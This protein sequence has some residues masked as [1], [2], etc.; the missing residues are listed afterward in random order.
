MADMSS[1]GL[2]CERE[3]WDETGLDAVHTVLVHLVHLPSAQLLA[4]HGAHH[5]AVLYMLR[6]NVNGHVLPLFV[7]V[8]TSTALKSSLDLVVERS[9]RV[10]Q[11]TELTDFTLLETRQFIG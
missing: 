11:I 5:S 8:L 1:F 3:G 4:A 7:R 2:T 6:S 10:V 9:D